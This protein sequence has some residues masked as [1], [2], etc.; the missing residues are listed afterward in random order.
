MGSSFGTRCR[1]RCSSGWY[2][3]ILRP[4]CPIFAPCS[5]WSSTLRAAS[6]GGL[7]PCLTNAA[8]DARTISGRDE[9]TAPLQPNKE[10][11]LIKGLATRVPST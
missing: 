9:E 2:G 1:Y 5:P 10:T 11:V 6:G 7:R 8:R 4:T 3:M